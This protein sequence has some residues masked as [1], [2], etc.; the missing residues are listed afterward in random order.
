MPQLD[1]L[2]PSLQGV[3]VSANQLEQVHIT[4]SVTFVK[5]E[6][7]EVSSNRIKTVT[8]LLQNLKFTPKLLILDLTANNLTSMALF[9]HK[10]EFLFMKLEGNPWVS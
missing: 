1:E 8:H 3:K 4:Q 9:T 7:V 5:L 10:A 2:A 6:I